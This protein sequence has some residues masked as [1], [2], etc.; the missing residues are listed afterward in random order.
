MTMTVEQRQSLE[1]EAQAKINDASTR[2]LGHLEAITKQFALVSG[3]DRTEAACVLGK[4]ITDSLCEEKGIE[5][6]K[7]WLAEMSKQICGTYCDDRKLMGFILLHHVS[8]R[9]PSL[10][11]MGLSCRPSVFKQSG[12][13]W[14]GKQLQ[15]TCQASRLNGRTRLY[16]C[17]KME[18]TELDATTR[19]TLTARLG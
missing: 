6:K 10:K 18:Q 16:H 2:R 19:E 8:L 1:Q 5:T 15:T 9:I 17:C 14:I 11:T 13:D 7:K 4:L 3:T 12:P